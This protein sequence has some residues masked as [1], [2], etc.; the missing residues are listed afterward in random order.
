[1]SKG[2]VNVYVCQKC[3]GHTVTIDRDDG[4]TPFMLDC[5]A[6]ITLFDPFPKCKGI[7]ESS[8]YRPDFEHGPP[9]WEWYAPDVNELHKITDANTL[10]HVAMGGLLLRLTA[11]Q[12][13]NEGGV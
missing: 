6:G 12:A 3:G 10:R 7:A 8:F 1:M 9:E 2:Q 13:H 11:A 5:R 4:T